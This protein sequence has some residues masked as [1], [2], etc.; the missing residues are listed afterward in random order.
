M[1]LYR[2]SPIKNE[3]ELLEAIKYTHFT[4]FELCKKA[5]NKYLPV[6]GNIGIF[7]H[8]EKEFK[9]LNEIRKKLTDPASPSFNAKYFRLYKPIVIPA[10]GDIPETTYTYLYVRQP[11]KFRNQV[12]DVD[13]VIEKEKYKKIEDSRVLNNNVEIF[14]RPDL[15]MCEL[16]NPDFD[17]LVYL[18]TRTMVEAIRH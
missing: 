16:F 13:F 11:D 14:N 7:C 4:S 5:L 12:G 8:Y 3:E 1:K 9:I 6:A 17:V 18:T 10:K 2:F 15:V